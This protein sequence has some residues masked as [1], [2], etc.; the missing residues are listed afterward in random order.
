VLGVVGITP[1]IPTVGP[2]FELSLF[3]II[4][5]DENDQRITYLAETRNF[6]LQFAESIF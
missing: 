4:V 6:P 3:D 1:N 5:S 2:L